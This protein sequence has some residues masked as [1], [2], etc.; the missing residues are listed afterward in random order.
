MIWWEQQKVK[1]HRFWFLFRNHFYFILAGTQLEQY[2]VTWEHG[3]CPA[4]VNIEVVLKVA[5]KRETKWNSHSVLVHDSSVYLQSDH[6]KPKPDPSSIIVPEIEKGCEASP[7]GIQQLIR[8]RPGVLGFPGSLLFPFLCSF[9]RP[10]K[11]HWSIV[12]A[13]LSPC[14]C[15]RFLSAGAKSSKPDML[16]LCFSSGWSTWHK[17]WAG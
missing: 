13:R 5:K 15:I 6:C 1:N 12:R 2:V 7:W 9:P 4:F 14:W 16:H 11:A 8:L 10:L 3:N 17:S